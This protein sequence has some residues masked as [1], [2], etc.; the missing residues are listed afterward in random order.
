MAMPPTLHV[1]TVDQAAA[2]LREWL[3]DM[4]VEHVYMWDSIGGMP[5]ALADRHVALLAQLAPLVAE[6]GVL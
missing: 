6:I 4:P 1:L 2:F 5:D 3:G